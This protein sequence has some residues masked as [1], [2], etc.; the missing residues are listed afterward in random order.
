MFANGGCIKADPIPAEESSWGIGNLVIEEN[1]R[2]L[3]ELS[4]KAAA[5]K[6]AKGTAS[7][8]IGDFWQTA[9]DT[10][11]IEKDDLAPLKPY[12]DK[13]AAINDNKSLQA[14]LAEFDKVGINGLIDFSVYQDAKNSEVNALQMWQTGLGL[15]E[16]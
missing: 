5:E 8:K 13:I 7:Q 12:L 1:T 3:R 4:E 14:V 10:V 15:G 6:A 9:M 2:R 16:F 11:K